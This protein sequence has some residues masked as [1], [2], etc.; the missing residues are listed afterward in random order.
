MRRRLIQ[1]LSS[2]TITPINETWKGGHVDGLAI[3]VLLIHV[4][5]HASVL[6][7]SGIKRRGNGAGARRYCAINSLGSPHT[8]IDIISNDADADAN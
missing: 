3:I 2:R 8:I 1:S 7:D 5:L 4:L 6:L